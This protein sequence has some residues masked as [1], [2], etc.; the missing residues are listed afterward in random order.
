M[1][2]EGSIYIYYCSTVRKEKINNVLPPFQND[3]WIVDARLKVVD[4]R[5]Y[6]RGNLDHPAEDCAVGIHQS[7]WNG[8]SITS[9]TIQPYILF[10][11][12]ILEYILKIRTQAAEIHQNLLITF[13]NSAACVHNYFFRFYKCFISWSCRRC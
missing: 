2:W 5:N 3:W 4:N 13:C 10:P 7:F 11:L 1:I 12:K 9:S 8:G 6:Y